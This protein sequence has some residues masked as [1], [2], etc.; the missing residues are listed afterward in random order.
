VTVRIDLDRAVETVDERFL[1]FAVD[2]AELVGGDFWAPAASAQGLLSTH[3]VARYDFSRPRLRRLTGALAPAYL[4]I[5]GTD[6]DRTVYRLDDSAGADTQ[7]PEG[8]RWVL[9]RQRWDEVN[10]F[11]R[12]LDL[13]IMFTL[14]AGPS[15]RDADGGWSAES[16][17]GLIDYSQ[18]HQYPVDVWELGNEIN[19][20]PLTHGSWLSG[21]RYARD[22]GRARAL[23][24]ELHAPA[25]LA[26]GGSAFWPVIGE[27]RSI[28]EDTLRASG[29]ALDIVT[30]HYYPQQSRRCPLA[31][32]RADLAQTASLERLAEV[33]RWAEKVES[34]ARKHAPRAE[35]WLGETASAQ[36][37]GETGVSNTFAD[38]LWWVDELGRVAR[39]GQQVVVRQTLSGSDYGLIDDET[40]QPNP[41]YWVSWLWRQLAG[42]RV[43]D[44]VVDPL[45]PAVR[46]YAHCLRAGAGGPE[47]GA[48]VVALLNV[49]PSASATVSFAAD[50]AALGP[51]AV[52]RVQSDSLASKTVRLNGT[53][54]EAAPDGSP[55]ALPA[56]ASA[57]DTK[58]ASRLSIAPLSMAFVVFPH[59]AATA[60][61]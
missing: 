16:A 33:D 49:H 23:L 61:R 9:T 24:T 1:S 13:R 18:R 32:R 37:G 17:R 52:L 41:S 47:R 56:L 19:A 21:K 31:T 51:A 54:L 27:G 14:N 25:R 34:A 6:A 60:C 55:P 30:W 26:G 4:R 53:A 10:E 59:A 43:L 7:I 45:A 42:A 48:I 2:T 57:T 5:G 20:F 44:A 12:A 35:V 38:A 40:M 36:C 46:A 29:D 8:A 28:M 15:A 11:A 58:A 3:P 50:A 22:L 39:R